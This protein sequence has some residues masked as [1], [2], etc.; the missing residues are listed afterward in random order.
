MIGQLSEYIKDTYGSKRGMLRY[1]KFKVLYYLG[2]FKQYEQIDF[3]KV[4]KMVFICSGNICRSPFGEALAKMHLPQS[5]S[6]GLHC[7]GGDPADQRAIRYADDINLD[8]T[9][10]VTRHIRE[11]I[12]E[13]TD[14]LIVMEP[15]HLTELPAYQKGE[16]QI[17]LACLWG[18][19]PNP[20]LHDPFS[21]NKHFFAKCEAELKLAM[22]YI[23]SKKM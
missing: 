10:H 5:E 7:R 12:P 6:F 14:L 1:Y 2:K 15:K 18:E 22:D 4:E 21:A 16:P 9:Q 19:R 17:T 11:Y 23:F 13:P 3:S 20:Y 8:L